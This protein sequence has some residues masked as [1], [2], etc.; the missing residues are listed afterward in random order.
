MKKIISGLL[1]TLIGASLA[2]ALPSQVSGESN[3]IDSI[4]VFGDSIASGYGLDPGTEYNY[5]QI[6]GDY[7]GCK[8]ENYA[9]S[10][11]TTA[12]LV[13]VVANLSDEQKK[14]IADSEVVVI[15]IGG[16][17][18]M[19]YSSKK[20]LDFA[21]SDGFLNE[22]Y[23]KN[24]IPQN[25][26]IN[27]LLKYMN[28]DGKG[29]L[30]EYAATG[31]MNAKLKLS[32]V[33]ADI[34]SNL[35]YNTQDNEGYIGNVMIPNIKE[36]VSGIRAVNPDARIII[37]SVYN[38]L[39]FSPE[40]VEKNL[41]EN[42]S[43]AV[44]MIRLRFKDILENY[45]KEL[46]GIEGVEVADILNEFT[47]LPAD[48]DAAEQGYAYY[49][50]DI[51]LDDKERDFH[52]NQ[53]GHLAIAAEILDTIGV[54]HDDNGLM[55]NV[56]RHLPNPGSNIKYPFIAL[57]TYKKVAGNLMMGDV[58]F[59]TIVTGSD[60]TMALTEYTILSSELPTTF[61]TLQKQCA[62]IDKNN[63]ITGSDAQRILNYYT[64]LS[65]GGKLT[66]DEYFYSVG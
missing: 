40:Y 12:D 4:A 16:N 42:K 5:G 63:I 31:G 65:S 9:V 57:D 43:M 30:I 38:P 26:G 36:A 24:D 19:N 29:G 61:S 39:Q 62:D 66:P 54:L 37:Q 3:D 18:L 1:S 27:D 53:R 44:G 45:R 64:Y 11:D 13:K 20:L 23:T 47:S 59:D 41:S 8:V 50:T 32:R 60:A 2:V 15:S 33:L 35:C 49:F 48:A 34:S 28:I 58:N 10:G 25:P 17:D 21:V 56:F 52:P 51:Q 55:T 7:L 22:G 46:N 6:I 14:F